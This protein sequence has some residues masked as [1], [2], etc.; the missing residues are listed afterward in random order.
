MHSLCS[1]LTLQQEMLLQQLQVNR[2]Q[3][4]AATDELFSASNSED[5]NYDM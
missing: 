5:Q 4:M 2:E 3:M 1:V